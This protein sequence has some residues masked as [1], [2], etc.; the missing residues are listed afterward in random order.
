MDRAL[1]PELRLPAAET[2]VAE[3]WSLNAQHLRT[4]HDNA[5]A[6]FDPFGVLAPLIH[7][8]VERPP[9][10]LQRGQPIRRRGRR[11]PPQ[12]VRHRPY[13]TVANLDCGRSS[14]LCTM[15][16]LFFIAHGRS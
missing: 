10:P 13:L 9:G 16:T 1:S 6:L 7:A 4:L 3:A 2:R 8:R 5:E 14:A 15:V 11:R 12:A